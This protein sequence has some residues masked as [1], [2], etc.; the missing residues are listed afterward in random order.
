MLVPE[1]IAV[2]RISVIA[3]L[4]YDIPAL[5]RGFIPVLVDREYRTLSGMENLPGSG[6]VNVLIL[7]NPENNLKVLLSFEEERKQRKLSFADRVFFMRNIG[8]FYSD[9]SEDTVFQVLDFPVQKS[10]ILRYYQ[11]MDENQLKLL[12]KKGLNS[13][14]EAEYYY[15]IAQ[16]GF[17]K[18]LIKSPL[19]GKAFRMALNTAFELY[20]NGNM[21]H[22][23]AIIPADVE[24]FLMKKRYP[25]FF[26][27]LEKYRERR[28]GMKSPKHIKVQTNPFFEGNKLLIEIEL[29]NSQQ[30]EEALQ[31]LKKEKEN[32]RKILSLF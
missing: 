4:F 21:D 10:E 3:P 29:K 24:S 27:H 14:R 28:E 7:E 20:R 1:R 17:E 6:E 2:E 19:E 13:L 9:L 18:V 12:L 26:S 30:I 32:L 5:F 11:N 22:F 8:K 15:Y 16:T 31:F 23:D 25:L